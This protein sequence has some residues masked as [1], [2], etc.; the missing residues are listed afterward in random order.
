MYVQTNSDAEGGRGMDEQPHDGPPRQH[1][2]ASTLFLQVAPAQ[3]LKR[4]SA[5]SPLPLPQKAS[6]A[7]A[8]MLLHFATSPAG[9]PAPADQRRSE[10]KE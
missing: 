2:L 10:R 3:S 8:E 7:V 5:L 9:R 4:A 6:T 1:V